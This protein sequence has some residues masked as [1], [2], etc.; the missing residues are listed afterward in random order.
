MKFSVDE[1]VSTWC[2]MI[3]EPI[4]INYKQ[5][6]LLSNGMRILFYN[7]SI[8][9]ESQSKLVRHYRKINKY[10]NSEEK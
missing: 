7:P 4:A 10:V 8:S 6:F 3:E 9:R 2:P 1:F 5:G